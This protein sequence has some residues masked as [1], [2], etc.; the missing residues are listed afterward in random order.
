MFWQE[1]YI[2]FDRLLLLDQRQRGQLYT[3]LK[4]GFTSILGFLQELSITSIR[5][6][7]ST[8]GLA[9]APSPVQEE[10]SIQSI[11]GNE[12][13]DEQVKQDETEED[14]EYWHGDCQ[15]MAP[16]AGSSVRRCYHCHK[17]GHLKRQCPQRRTGGRGRGTG[18]GARGAPRQ[19]GYSRPPTGRGRGSAPPG[20]PWSKETL[21]RTLAQLTAQLQNQ[22]FQLGVNEDK[23]Q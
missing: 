12:L 11:F 19:Y 4:N 8:G 21:T 15:A 6:Y 9:S 7:T 23:T 22:D 16:Q 10:V 1:L 14:R 17:P 5:A 2:S 18:P 13:G 20:K 3:A